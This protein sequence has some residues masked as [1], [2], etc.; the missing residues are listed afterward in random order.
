VTAPTPPSPEH[1]SPLGRR[2][3]R[4][5]A[6][7]R[8]WYSFLVLAAAFLA[9]FASPLVITDRALIVC[10]RGEWYL[11]AVAG[12]YPASTF[13]QAGAGEARYRELKEQVRGTGDWVLLAPYPYHPN[14]SLLRDPTLKGS[15]PH[16][17]SRAHWFGTDD[18]DR[19]VF[20]RLVY[21]FR[22]S[23]G[24]GLAVVAASYALGTLVGAVLGWAGGRVDLVGQRLVEIW[25]LMP[26]LYT[27][28]I[29]ASVVPPSPL[30]LTVLLSAFGWVPIA[31]YV[32]GEVY[33]EKR[34]DYV[35]AA[36]AQGEPDLAIV[37]V[38]VL[39]NALTPV[40]SFAPFALVG[41]ISALVS[42]DFLGF[43][44]PAPTPSWGE[45]VQQ[46]LNH[47]TDWHLVVFP[48]GALFVTLLLVVFVGE[49]A[50]DA[51]DPKTTSR[52]R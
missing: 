16:P 22:L 48:L 13:G 7:R 19:D 30:L 36:V 52:L 25:S 43:G 34:R 9:S 3:R 44:L 17:P 29:V 33:R 47:L 37:A 20:A 39:P 38:H 31:L 35:V 51:F 46:G 10:W 32:R 12:F 50:R 18:R 21:G 41:A 42:L 4:F 15:P 8:G 14:E 6:S 24:L 45:L 23:F 40:V 11:P 27:T 5:R 2:W 49:A 28:I 26:F 1:A